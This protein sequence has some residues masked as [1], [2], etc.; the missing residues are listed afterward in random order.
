MNSFYPQAGVRFN[1]TFTEIQ[2]AHFARDVEDHAAQMYQIAFAAFA[3]A[4]D[5]SQGRVL[6]RFNFDYLAQAGHNLLLLYQIAGEDPR[7]NEAKVG[8]HVNL[9]F[10]AIIGAPEQLLHFEDDGDDWSKDW[11]SALD[12]GGLL[13]RLEVDLALAGAAK[14]FE[15]D[16]MIA[17]LS[18]LGASTARVRDYHFFLINEVPEDVDELV[19]LADD[20]GRLSA[21][22]EEAVVK[23]RARGVLDSAMA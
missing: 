16:E 9:L 13:A 12:R 15:R 7:I 5:S 8:R 21:M 3:R 23:L 6:K 19:G 18:R 11:R 17:C 20:A 14:D 10:W 4:A 22:L 2:F 1:P